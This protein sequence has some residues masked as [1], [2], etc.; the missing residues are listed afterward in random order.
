MSI[1]KT[2]ITILFPDRCPFCKTIISNSEYVCKNCK[3]DLP[4]YGVYQGVYGGYRCASPLVY[5]DKYKYSVL[6][7]K[8]HNK[9][10]YAEKFAVLLQKEIERSYPEM[11]FDCIT[12]VPMHRFDEFLRGYNQSE[13]L[14][15]ELSKIT[16]IPFVKT[17]YKTKRITPQHKLNAKKRRT[18]IK[19]VFKLIDKKPVKGKSVLLIDDIIT[20]GS[21]LAECSKI[22]EKAKPTKICCL[23]LLS[24]ADIY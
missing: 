7:F 5:K 20:T 24:T 2:L 13:L 1:I 12:C 16:N 9:K 23:T 18:N 15:K 17:I 22:I 3:K 14:A 10:Q 6:R 11:I 19:G 21:T 8:F 4:E